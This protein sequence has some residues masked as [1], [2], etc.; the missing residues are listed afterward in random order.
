MAHPTLA[1]IDERIAAVAHREH[2]DRSVLFELLDIYGKPA[3]TITRLK[4]GSLNAAGDPEREVALRNVVYWR[5]TEPANDHGEALLTELEELKTTAAV[6]RLR[7]RFVV[8]TDYHDLVV[9]DSKTGDNTYTP[10]SR[11]D[12][13]ATFFLPWAGMEKAQYAPESPADTKAAERMGALFDELLTANPDLLSED[14]GR[15]RL[16]VFFTR[17]LFCYFAED[18]GIF[19]EDQF[20]SAIGSNTRED[21]SDTQEFIST[22]FDALDT[23]PDPAAR[24]K[25]PSYVRGFPYVNGKLFTRDAAL[26]VP[27]FTRNARIMLLELGRQIWQDINPDIF[28]S[29]FQAIVDPSI[30]SNLGQHYTSVPNILKT[31]DPL[32]MDDLRDQLDRAFDSPTKLQRL[33]DRIGKI[34]IFD[35]AC[36]SGNFLIIAYKELRRLEHA[37]LE[38]LTEL[39]PKKNFLFHD[40]VIRVENFYGIE[41]DD[42]AVEVAVLSLWIA[43]HQMNAEFKD[44]FGTSIPLIPLR[45]SGNIVAGNAARLDWHKICPNDREE[46]IYLI[47]NPPYGGSKTLSEYQKEDYQHALDNIKYSKDLDYISLWFFKGAEFIRNSRAQLAFVSTNSVSQGKHVNLLF[48]PIFALGIEIGFAYTS[49]KWENAAKYNAGVSVVVIGLRNVSNDQKYIYTDKISKISA[50]DINGYLADA[51]NIIVKDRRSAFSGDFPSMAF[52]SMPRDGGNL[53]IDAITE[54]RLDDTDPGRKWIK[55]YAGAKDFING[56]DRFC[57]WIDDGDEYQARQVPW[58]SERLDRVTAKRNQSKAPSTRHYALQPHRFVQRAYKPTDAIIVPATSSERRDYVPMGYVGPETVISN[59]AFA[60]YDAEPWLF[61]LLESR[62]HMVWLRAVGGKL[63]TDF[64]YSNT[65]VYNTFPVPELTETVEGEL[66]EA[67]LHVLDVREYF[68]ERNLAELYDAEEMPDLLREAHARVD[69]IVDGLYQEQPFESDEERLSLLFAMYKD[70]TEA[71]D[72]A[73]A[74]KNLKKKVK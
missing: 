3:S 26:T 14:G 28:G 19:E 30:R 51:A 46:E 38:R 35:P 69:E 50:D 9:W 17:L 56:N 22:L 63:K 65:L 68:P 66:T 10:L 36:G 34:K 27:R 45:E 6:T 21:G 24:E 5:E 70:A 4:K 20:T 54:R 73:T 55:R 33:L 7:P 32:F 59:A 2:Y 40:S 72:S 31:I 37:I 23:P 39:N 52:G 11:I 47:G 12:E 44:K 67:G 57:L 64:R 43:K 29:M 16:N 61:A 53:I 48:P 42:F 8:V 58:I 18:T 74:K 60:V 15:H 1:Q 62:M 25:L 49:F 41:I 71:E 13:H